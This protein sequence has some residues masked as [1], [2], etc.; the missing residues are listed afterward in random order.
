MIIF[1]FL[2]PGA[3]YTEV[4]THWFSKHFHWRQICERRFGP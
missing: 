3:M 4:R 1:N 2:P